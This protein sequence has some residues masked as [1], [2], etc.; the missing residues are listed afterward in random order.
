MS[1]QQLVVRLAALGRPQQL[2]DLLD[3]VIPSGI[4]DGDVLYYTSSGANFTVNTLPSIDGTNTV[5]KIKRTN[6]TTSLSNGELY[7]SFA[8]KKLYIGNSTNHLVTVAGEYY[9]DLANSIFFVANAGFDQANT[10]R[11]HANAGFDQANTA[12]VHANTAYLTANA[13]FDQANTARTHANAGF[14]QANTARTHA[15][16]GFDQANT[17]RTHANAGFDQAN[18]ARTHANTAHLTANAGFDQANT[19]RTHANTIYDVANTKLNL[20]GGTIA[21]DLVV[22]GNIT[23]SG[24]TSYANTIHLLIGDNILTL[25][26]DLPAASSPS[27]N[28][29][30]EIN[31]G[32]S[33]N[34]AL[35]WNEGTDNWTFTN[36]GTNYFRIPTNTAVETATTIGQNAFGQTNT[37][38]L[39]A[40]TARDVAN[41]AFVKA[42]VALP[43]V[44]GSVFAGDLIVSGNVGIG[45]TAPTSNLH[46]IGTANITGIVSVGNTVNAL[47]FNS[48][49]DIKYKTDVQNIEYALDT[50]S[51]LRGV[52]FVWKESEKSS[53]GLI[54]QEVQNII[55]EIV[56]TNNLS[57]SL[58]YDAL[59]GHLVES[60]KELKSR[61]E[62]LEKN[63]INKRKQS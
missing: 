52:S 19:A 1:S 29:G 40:N 32:S 8:D 24:Q 36:D 55:P 42:N 38:Y 21:G 16:A 15:N 62:V 46:I 61:I 4:K 44:S 54:A 23:V 37:A 26:A 20:S 13:A 9:V 53:F 17:A 6:N 11:T 10:A 51:K 48:T 35:I 22:S 57:L 49:S 50:V 63:V 43:N 14:D 7:Y 47:D 30:L 2:S 33:A 18:T 3:V 5:I 58:N 39:Q 60:I 28:A 31:R 12:R 56:S 25:N 41:L 45:I 59:I 34:V 27:E